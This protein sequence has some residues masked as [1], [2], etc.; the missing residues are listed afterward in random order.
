MCSSRSSSS[1][2]GTV[3]QLLTWQIPIESCSVSQAVY[4]G[5][6]LAHC[7]LRLPGSSDSPASASQSLLL[8]P[9]LECN[10]EVSAHCNVC[11][12]G[13]SDF[14][15]SASQMIPYCVAQA[16]VQWQDLGSL[17][18]PSPGFKQFSCLSLLKMG[19][20]HGGQAGLELVTS[21]DLPAFISL[22]AG[23]TGM[24]HRAWPKKLYF[25]GVTLCRPSW[26][27]VVL[28]WLT[29]T[30][31]SR[32]Q[33]I[34]VP[35]LPKCNGTILA[36]CSLSLLGSSNPSVSASQ[37]W[38]FT[39][40][41][42]LVLN[43]WPQAVLPPEITGMSHCAWPKPVFLNEITFRG[44]RME[45]RS[46]AQAGVQWHDLGSL[47]PPPSRFKRFSLLLNTWDYSCQLPRLA[48]FCIF[49]RDGA[50]QA[51]SSSPSASFFNTKMFK[52]QGLPHKL[53]GTP[54]G[55][56]QQ[57]PQSLESSSK[58]GPELQ[59]LVSKCSLFIAVEMQFLYV[60]QA[61]LE[62]LTS[63]DL[64]ASASQS[65]GITEMG[66]H[67]VSQAGLELLTS[68]DLLA[69]ASQSVGI[70]G[71]NLVLRKLKP[72]A[73]GQLLEDAEL[74]A[75][76]KLWSLALLPRLECSDMI[77]AHCNLRLPGSGDSPASASR[78][79][80]TTGGCHHTRLIGILF[81][82]MRL[83]HVGQGGLELLTSSDL[84]ASDSQS[85]GIIVVQKLHQELVA[86]PWGLL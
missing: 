54:I 72:F 55:T 5:S 53:I 21:G 73:Q 78:V 43:S 22:S 39:M 77:S 24:S 28:S 57:L 8:L 35:H 27:A 25:L 34:L 40:L 33:A 10:G 13:S 69:L 86:L 23:I 16:G 65:A 18:P 15:A 3:A 68:I 4:N 49:S 19:F 29:A 51:G 58:E 62:L 37:R 84:P 67:H 74:E 36:H 56:L 61:G 46:V 60:A 9:R 50:G 26:S 66:F 45:S 59:L 63:G 1:S 70:T 71:G 64:P 81:V 44:S 30:S 85:A 75:E 2:G 7:N 11:L 82:E 76:F 14:P 38:G 48:N 52:T 80:E 31:A 41:P 79:A 20:C 42:R 47:Q 17:Q 12:P 6:S 32:V 83:H